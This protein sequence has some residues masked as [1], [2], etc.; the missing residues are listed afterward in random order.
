MSKNVSA[1]KEKAPPVYIEPRYVI[2]LAG[3]LLGICTVVALLLG[4]INSV[5]SPIIS[6]LQKEKT[7]AAMRKVLFAENYE[8]LEYSAQNVSAM[9]RAVSGG[10]QVGY[11]VEVTG[12]GF[13][14]AMKLVVGVDMT[15]AVTGVAVTKHSETSGVGT[16]VTDSQSVLERFIGMDG[17]IT[18]V[19]NEADVNG[20]ENCVVAVAGATVSSRA[21]T[22]AINTALE[23]VAA[24]RN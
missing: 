10:E 6:Q 1:V 12:S 13:G 3:T 11:V 20:N 21:V 2:K 18:V 4:L 16:K 5:T 14:G 9:Y 22:A 17:A 8:Q 7:D 24:V 15:G 19:K 23:A